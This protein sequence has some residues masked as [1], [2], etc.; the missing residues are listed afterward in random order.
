VELARVGTPPS[1]EGRGGGFYGDLVAVTKDLS[2][3]AQALGGGM[4]RVV[5]LAS[6]QERWTVRAAEE[7][8][9]ALAFSPDGQT[10]ASAA[11]FVESAVRLWDAAGGA[12][13]ARLEGHRT[14]VRSLAFEPGG[15]SLASGSADQTINL[16]DLRGLGRAAHATVPKLEPSATLRGH[17]LEVWSLAFA[18][19]GTTLVSGSKD[20]TVC[21]WDTVSAQRQRGLVTL[22]SPVL[23]WCFESGSGAI[24]GLDREGR[25]A[26]F[27]GVD[28]QQCDPVLET[29]EAAQSAWFSDDARFMATVTR[30]GKTQVWDIA[31]GALVREL[32]EG[33]GGVVPVGFLANSHRLITGERRGGGF[34]EWDIAG[35]EEV[36]QWRDDGQAGT[37]KSVISPDGQRFAGF[38]IEGS[39]WLGSLL[40]DTASG[41]DL[42]IR[43]ASAAAFSPDSR[44]LAVVNV[45]GECVLW[46]VP[47]A[48]KSATLRGFLQ[49][50]HSVAFSHD[51]RRL[52]V[53]SNGNEAVKIW[54]S[55]S[56]REL[57]TLAGRG[58]MFGSVGFSPD[59]NVLAAS[60]SRGV[61]HVWSA[62]A[63]DE[64]AQPGTED[65]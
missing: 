56:R 35:G 20:G 42:D 9:T 41:V 17:R 11:G 44:S 52:A 6:G 61:L 30:G 26:R 4:V 46:D 36:R 50:A 23:A 28:F 40:S 27:G 24:L 15:D 1:R 12:E 18:P 37:W 55:E 43:Q 49:G 29:G 57:L 14:F 39:A 3:A 33:E 21:V 58:S 64:V 65:L 32:A 62:P 5:D 47:E 59:G 16:W 34:R 54:D 19:G 25:L 10:L 31:E 53:G 60:N 45:L 38:D 2:L 13:L 8:V 48:Q 7:S 51:G 22:P 63:P